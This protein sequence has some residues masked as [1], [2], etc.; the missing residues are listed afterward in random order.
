V[1]PGSDGQQSRNLGRRPTVTACR[2]AD[3]P[4]FKLLGDGLERRGAC[5]LDL[6]NYRSRC[7]AVHTRAA[8]VRHMLCGGS[9]AAIN[10]FRSTA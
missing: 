9:P 5:P 7:R 2:G 3:A 10:Q 6:G 8:S 4:C 1:P